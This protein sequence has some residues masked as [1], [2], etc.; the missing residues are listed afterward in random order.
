MA[1]G[2]LHHGDDQ[3]EEKRVIRGRE[4]QCPPQEVRPLISSIFDTQPKVGAYFWDKQEHS[5]NENTSKCDIQHLK[6]DLIDAR[7]ALGKD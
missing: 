4:C 6:S 2:L 7:R 3:V 5:L 1:R